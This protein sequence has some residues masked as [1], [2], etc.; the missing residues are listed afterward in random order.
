MVADGMLPYLRSRIL[1]L[2]RRPG[3]YVFKDTRGN[4]LYVGKAKSLKSRVANY[5][6]PAEG[7][8]A[9][10][11]LA[12]EATDVE[13]L[14]TNTETEALALEATLIQKHEPPYN[15]RLVDDS[16]YLYVRISRDT[17]PRVELVR[18][19]RADDAWYRGPYPQ[20]TAIRRT[21]KEA[22]RLFPWCEYGGPATGHRPQAIGTSDQGPI[23]KAQGLR[24]KAP[25]Y[26]Y[27]LGLCQGICVGRIS[28][29]EYQRSIHGLK[30]FLDGDIGDALA[31]LKKQMADA[32]EQHKYEQAA[33]ARDAIAAIQQATTPQH[34]ATP[35]RESLDALDVARFGTRA[36]VTLLSVRHGRVVG[37]RTFP[38]TAPSGESSAAVLRS[39]LLSYA[40]RAAGGATELILPERV[41]DAEL[42]QPNVSVP[43]RGWKRRLLELARANAEEALAQAT[44]ELESPAALQVALKSLA[45]VLHLGSPPH[46]IEAY[47]I[48]N[49]QGTLATG[50]M[51][52]FLGGLP[53]RNAYKKFKIVTKETPDDVGMMKEVLRRRLRGH[54]P[55]DIG[56]GQRR[57]KRARTKAQGPTPNTQEWPLPNLILLDGGKGQLNAGTAILRELKIGIPVAALA[58]PH[59][60]PPSGGTP[61]GRP[62]VA[63]ASPLDPELAVEGRGRRED[64]GS[65]KLY[66]P[67]QTRPIV[68]PLSSPA[69]YL[70]QRIRDEAHRFTLGYHQLLRKKRMTRSILEEI[71][72]VGDV[73][74]KKL[75]R[76]FG[77]LRGIRTASRE[78]LAKVVGP[79]LA[80]TI[81]GSLGNPGKA[82]NAKGKT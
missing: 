65:E 64:A 58:K 75:L 50:S 35:R 16:S 9:Q 14:V 51:V 67:G 72:G 22:R 74:R 81:G 53:K 15:I 19:V 29:E 7:G 76:T 12:K 70:L 42:L 45:R 63:K 82:Q 55:W 4:V 77:S 69:L 17:Y 59:S 57:V 8:T 73:T 30:R 34:V 49:I 61:R 40:L 3:V 10:F 27:H 32:S 20:A 13:T 62:H 2:P 37:T 68:L 71:P 60:V 52:V 11:L 43:Q 5:L 33:K 48:S 56:Q 54:G 1:G 24:P 6:A 46:R 66:V 25:C 79:K 26:A 41:E 23:P 38:L 28:L 39:F 80:E 31:S 78:E 21:L 36:V 18:R 47:D 44:A